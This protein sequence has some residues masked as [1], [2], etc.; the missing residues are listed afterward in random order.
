MRPTPVIPT[1][2][3]WMQ[4][5]NRVGDFAGNGIASAS[6]RLCIG[7]RGARA[8]KKSSIVRNYFVLPCCLL[9]LNLCIGLV[10]YKAKVIQDPFLQTGAVIAMV[11]FGGSLVAFVLSPSIE[12][13]VATLRRGSRRG[14]GELGEVLFLLALGGLVFWLYY[15][16][17]IR[18]PEYLLP[19]AWRNPG[20]F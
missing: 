18:G 3:E 1:G 8:M 19:A 17:Y 16:M 13:L 14:M 15:R 9:L 2:A 6:G 11:L 10:G 5:T 4:A 20:R 12:T 7:G